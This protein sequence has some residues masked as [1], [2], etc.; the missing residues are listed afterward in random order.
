[1]LLVGIGNPYRSDDRVGLLVIQMLKSKQLPGITCIEHNGDGAD[2]LEIMAQAERVILIDAVKSGVVPGTIHRFDMHTTW[3]PSA[4]TFISSHAFG[5][6]EAIQLARAI[7]QLPAYLL[8]YGIECSNFGTGTVL[9]PVVEQAV[10]G[11]VDL[12]LED[13]QASTLR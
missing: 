9:S 12:I 3:W 2:L 8:I 5:V 7:K 10:P 6:G 4:M 1:M 13:I 11:V